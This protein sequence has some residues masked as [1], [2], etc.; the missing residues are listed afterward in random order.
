MFNQV[1]NPSRIAFQDIKGTILAV[2]KHPSEPI[3]I[4]CI[5]IKFLDHLPSSLDYQKVTCH[6][7][8]PLPAHLPPNPQVFAVTGPVMYTK[9]LVDS[10]MPIS[11]APQEWLYP[12]DWLQSSLRSTNKSSY[13]TMNSAHPQGLFATQ[14]FHYVPNPDAINFGAF[15][16]C[17]MW[18]SQDFAQY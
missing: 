15:P 3:S 4:P 7:A 17:L 13:S 1:K 9:C 18:Q 5:S 6:K 11:I 2:C 8:I 10:G 12:A 16:K 14:A